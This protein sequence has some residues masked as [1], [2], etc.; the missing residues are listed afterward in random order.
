MNLTLSA[1][2]QQ[3]QK[4]WTMALIQTSMMD[5]PEIIM[6]E[7]GWTDIARERKS[8]THEQASTQAYNSI[9]K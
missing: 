9:L 2:L 1:V 3:N 8:I 5:C 4:G 7:F 6:P